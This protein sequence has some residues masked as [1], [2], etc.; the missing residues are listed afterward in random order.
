M[1]E[2]VVKAVAVGGVAAMWSYLTLKT[3]GIWFYFT[4]EIWEICDKIVFPIP[5]VYQCENCS[6]YFTRDF[7]TEKEVHDYYFYVCKRCED[8]EIKT[9]N[10]D[11]KICI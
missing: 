8:E 2:S 1:A 11:E 5:L 10:G 4:H 6:H 7:V 9:R 3:A